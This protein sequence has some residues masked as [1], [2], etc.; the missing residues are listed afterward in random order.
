MAPSQGS[1]Q[2]LLP[3]F[4]LWRT[5][6]EDGAWLF[7]TGADP[8]QTYFESGLPYGVN[9]WSSAAATAWATTA[10]A[11][12]VPAARESSGRSTPAMEGRLLR[13]SA[14]ALDPRGNPL[15]L[16]FAVE[17]HLL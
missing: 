11:L 8:I 1:R 12:A 13:V 2:Y 5:Q 10:L 15:H 16:V 17:L 7:E 4:L 9:Q 3:E 14:R 6:L